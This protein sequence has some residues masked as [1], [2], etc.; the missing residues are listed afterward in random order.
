MSRTTVGRQVGQQDTP[1][2]HRLEIAQRLGLS[3]TNSYVVVVCPAGSGSARPPVG[4]ELAGL[5]VE[6]IPDGVVE[7]MA[8][9]RCA[10]GP[11]AAVQDLPVS[12]RLARDALRLTSDDPSTGPT[13]LRADDVMGL[14]APKP[15]CGCFPPQL[16]AGS[17]EAAGLRLHNRARDQS[18]GG[19][20]VRQPVRIQ[21]SRIA[22]PWVFI[23]HR[24]HSQ[25]G[26]LQ[27]GQ[28][29]APVDDSYPYPCGGD[30]CRN[31]LMPGLWARERAGEGQYAGDND[32][33][34]HPVRPL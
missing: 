9:L 27:A 29:N 30:R 33:V 3:E 10:I 17:C 20:S 32:V 11:K 34:Q 15:G 22:P 23:Q 19:L 14:L 13:C 26:I 24:V 8:G 31:A 16:P 18:K 25:G 6:V 12:Y 4:A 2:G 7:R 5:D 28:G 1:N 21:R